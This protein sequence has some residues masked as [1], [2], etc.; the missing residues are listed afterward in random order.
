MSAFS[1]P[2]QHRADIVRVMIR[3]IKIGVIADARGKLHRHVF[4]FVKDASAQ[5]GVI[6]QSRCVRREQ[7]LK[8]LACFAPGRT[9]EGEKCI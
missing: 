1:G 9:T 6:A 5:R 2:R 7:T 3:R 8:H 4:L